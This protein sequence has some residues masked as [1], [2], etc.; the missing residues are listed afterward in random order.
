MDAFK[1]KNYKVV[2]FSDIVGYKIT[3]MQGCKRVD[4]DIRYNGATIRYSFD[5]SLDIRDNTHHFDALIDC[6][7][8][9]PGLQNNRTVGLDMNTANTSTNQL[10]CPKCG[11]TNC[12]PVVETS[13]SGKDFSAGKGC[14]GWVILGPIGILCGACGK[15]KKTTSTTY[16][17]CSGCGN[18]FQC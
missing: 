1:K 17:M 7:T 18:K 16:W 4:M 11:S 8:M 14:C 9:I 6:L 12:T 15:G 5:D 3:P 2:N 10:H 13:T